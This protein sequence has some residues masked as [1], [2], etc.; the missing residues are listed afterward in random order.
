VGSKV[1]V[2]FILFFAR[3]GLSSCEI[4]REQR[5]TLKLLQPEQSFFTYAGSKVRIIFFSLEM[6]FLHATL[7]EKTIYAKIITARAAVFDLREVKD[8][9][10]IIYF[11]GGNGLFSCKIAQEN[12]LTVS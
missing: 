4:A 11:F 8:Q 9:G 12:D 3:N 6:D 10:Q 2:N 5:S 1:R 7:P